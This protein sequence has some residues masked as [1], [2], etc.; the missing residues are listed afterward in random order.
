MDIQNLDSRQNLD[1]LV[2]ISDSK[3]RFYGCLFETWLFFALAI[4][5]GQRVAAAKK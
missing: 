4:S 3:I 2:W 1:G 5:C